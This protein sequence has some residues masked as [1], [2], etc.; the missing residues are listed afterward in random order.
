MTDKVLK[1]ALLALFA[2]GIIIIILLGSKTYRAY[3]KI[4][5]KEAYKLIDSAIV[6]DVREK[7]EYNS[8]H[9]KGAINLPLAEIQTNEINLKKDDKIIVYCKSGSRSKMAAEALAE[10]GYKHVY[11][12]GGI[13]NWPYEVVK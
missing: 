3:E 8:G 5:R 11:D 13:A 10:L 12:L 4:S 6:I 1:I 2:I 9:I 7:Y